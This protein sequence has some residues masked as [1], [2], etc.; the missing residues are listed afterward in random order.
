MWTKPIFV[1]CFCVSLIAISL[2]SVNG[3]KILGFFVSPSPSHFVIDAALMRGLLAK[4]HNVIDS[5]KYFLKN[6]NKKEKN[7]LFSIIL[8]N[9]YNNS[10]SNKNIRT[11]TKL[12]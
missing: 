12:S 1:N 11:Y 3:A 9:C 7:D 8:V 6:H 4:G 10:C 2:G 5:K